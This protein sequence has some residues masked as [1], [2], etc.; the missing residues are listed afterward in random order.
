VDAAIIQTERL[1]LRPLTVGCATDMVSV[2]SDDAL[3]TFT[4]GQS[5][6]LA[7]LQDRYRSQVAG[8]GNDA[9]VWLNWILRRL[10]DDVTI[11]FLQADVTP[12]GVELA[13]L[14]GVQYQGAGFAV[15]AAAALLEWFVEGGASRITAHIHVDHLASQNV[16]TR[17]GLTQTNE[18]D[19]EGESVWML[20]APPTG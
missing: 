15:E 2:L 14:I 12:D 17:I 6:T 16:A 8:S 7:E 18:I 1:A 9:E 11:G 13:W 20:L 4:G 3:Y 5:P 10:T 19:D